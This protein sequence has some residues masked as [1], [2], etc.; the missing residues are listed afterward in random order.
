M[1]KL[2]VGVVVLALGLLALVIPSMQG[3][4]VGVPVTAEEA[5]TVHGACDGYTPLPATACGLPCF[6][7]GKGMDYDTPSGTIYAVHIVYLECGC[8]YKGP[9]NAYGCS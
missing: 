7:N 4:D 3:A 9:H 6:M 2:W 1:F 8:G 5:S